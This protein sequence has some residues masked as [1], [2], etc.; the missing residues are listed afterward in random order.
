MLGRCTPNGGPQFN[1]AITHD[2]A[3]PKAKSGGASTRPI[4]HR[5]HA[6]NAMS[7]VLPMLVDTQ[8]KK[9]NVALSFFSDLNHVLGVGSFDGENM[10]THRGRRQ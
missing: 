9:E 5:M 10:E 7:L 3:I 8:D 4:S 1:P 2:R 6:L